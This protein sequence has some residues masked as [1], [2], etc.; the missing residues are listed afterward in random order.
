MLSTDIDFVLANLIVERNWSNFR[1]K[2]IDRFHCHATKKKL[3]TVQWK[4]P[5]KWNVERQISEQFFQVS[6]HCGP[7]F[8]SYLPSVSRTFVELCME[9]PYWCTVSVHQYGPQKSTKTSGVPFFSKKPFLFTRELAYV[10]IIISFNSWNGYTAEN[11]ENRLFST[12]QHSYFGVTHCENSEV[13]I[14]F[15]RNGTC[16]WTGNLYK[17]LYFVYR[18]ST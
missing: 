1:E 10:R 2:V 16:C 3:E 14:A 4:K 13:Q 15:F 11:Q 9:A 6:G 7:Q 8:L 17:D 12:R 5:R 18:S